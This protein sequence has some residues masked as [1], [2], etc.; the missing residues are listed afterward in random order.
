MKKLDWFI[1][2][3][4]LGT[5][6]FM[7][8]VVMSISI[9]FDV[10]EKLKDFINPEN[11]LTFYKIIT[12]Y[13]PY[14]FI[15][16]ANLFSSL[17]IFLSVLWFTSFM[18]QRLEIVAILSNGVSFWRFSRPYI[19]ASSFL[20]V[21]S[22]LMNHYVAPYANKNRLDFE[23]KFTKYNVNF[24]DVH[25]EVSQGT[26]VSYRQFIGN[27][28]TVRRL[29][30]ENWKENENGQ[31]ELESDMQVERAEGD[32]VLYN[33]KLKNT[34]IRK[35]G[36]I[37]DELITRK[38]IDTVLSFNISDLGQ[39]S[40]ITYAMT[41]PELIKYREKEED[42]GNSIAQI[43]ISRHERTAYPFAAYILT[44]I[45]ISV[46]S[47][48]SRE[49]VG[50]NLVIGLCCGLVYVFFM[51]MTTVAAVNIG[52]NTIL[53]VWFPNI[54]FSIVAIFLFYKRLIF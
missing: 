1:V 46:A 38:L 26:I 33:W 7:I 19:I 53:A 8:G 48:K 17:I 43:D 36:K 5:Y 27:T 45:G 39:R 28:T 12:E 52:W 23:N 29:W 10:S 2:K 20:L 3:K 51:K 6:V 40:A 49:G 47:R 22:V 15:H 32:S 14:F 34:F 16:Y 35:I 30:V 42:K 4:F 50:K 31:W 44:V 54:F 9:I 41:T 11:N 18:A 13:Y 25:L 24:K 21:I 37:N